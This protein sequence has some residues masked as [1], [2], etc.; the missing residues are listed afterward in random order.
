VSVLQRSPVPAR[1]ISN[2]FTASTWLILGY[3]DKSAV[4]VTGL[5]DPRVRAAMVA[6]GI[7]LCSLGNVLE[8]LCERD[9]RAAIGSRLYSG[10]SDIQRN[11]V[12]QHLGL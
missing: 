1:T 4:E 7:E 10:A 9:M 2:S 6:E 11:L 5:C 3:V 8:R 12:V